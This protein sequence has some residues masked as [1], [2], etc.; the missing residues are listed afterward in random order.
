MTQEKLDEML[1]GKTPEEQ[2]EILK[3]LTDA[4]RKELQDD[5]QK[6]AAELDL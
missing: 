3:N 2:Q 4:E 5:L 6:R 1:L